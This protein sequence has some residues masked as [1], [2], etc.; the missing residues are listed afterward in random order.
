V[1]II[2]CNLF[3]REETI[4]HY[5]GGRA[6]NVHGRSQCLLLLALTLSVLPAPGTMTPHIQSSKIDLSLTSL[7]SIVF[8]RPVFTAAA[9]NGYP[10]KSFFRFFTK[11][12]NLAEDAIARTDLNLLNSTVNENDWGLSWGLEGFPRSKVARETGLFSNVTILTDIDVNDGKLFD[13]ASGA[14]KFDVAVLGF[15]EFV[16][17][18]EY[19][20]YKRFVEVGGGLFLLDPTNFLAE[21]KYN[22]TAKRVTLVKGHSWEFNGTA[23]WKGPFHRWLTENTNWVGSNYGLF[24]TMN[25]HMNGAIPNTTHP[26]SV[27]LRT[28]F[29][30]RIFSSYVAHEENEVTN[31]SDRVIAYWD[32]SGLKSRNLTVAA[33]EHEYQRGIVINTGIFGSD[34]IS[35]DQEMQFLLTAA[36]SHLGSYTSNPCST[37]SNGMDQSGHSEETPPEMWPF[38]SASSPSYPRLTDNPQESWE[39]KSVSRI[40][41]AYSK[42]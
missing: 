18:S 4:S 20:N 30:P 13:P 26:L 10:D 42:N 28:T 40:R 7:P 11:Y 34:L 39:T 8:I 15:S 36:V 37:S 33:Y 16:T 32:V 2:I 9:Y 1:S 14:R 41:S 25:Y 27:L 6:L 5:Y 17:M 24:H 31:S 29:G 19:Q 38:L 35:K 21:V 22:P 23:A 12:S 3:S